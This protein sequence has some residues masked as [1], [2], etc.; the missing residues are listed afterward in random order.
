MDESA[1]ALLEQQESLGRWSFPAYLGTHY[2]SLYAL[3]V[4]WLRFRG[5]SSRLNLNRLAEIL[6]AT[7]LPDGSWAQVRDPALDSGDINATIIN[8]AALKFFRSVIGI[9]GVPEAM[10]GARE[11][12]LKSGGLAAVNQFT[13]T[14]LALFGLHT[15]EDIRDIPYLIFLDG[16][17]QNYRRFSQWVI[18]HLIP[19]AY[20][21]HNRISRRIRGTFGPEL[22][23][24]ELSA[25]DGMRILEKEARPSSWYDGL[26]VRKILHQQRSYGSWGGYT[27][28]TLLSIAALDHFNRKCP[29]HSPSIPAA[30]KRGLEFVDSLYF[31]HGEGS[32]LG[33]LMHGAVW[34]TILAAQGLV[35]AGERSTAVVRAAR[36]LYQLQVPC[37][38]FPYGKDFEAY[39][40]VDDTSRALVVLKKMAPLTPGRDAAQS[41]RKG[42]RWLLKRQNCDGGWGAFDQ[43]NVGSRIVKLFTHRLS[44][45]VELFDASS[46]DST[47]HVLRALGAFGLTLRNCRAVRR[48]VRFLQ[49]AQDPV[50]GLWE[51]RWAIN[52]LYGTA[53]AGTGLI[54][55]GESSRS[56][57]L[58]RAAR[59][60]MAL[61]NSDGGFGESTLSYIDEEYRG[62]G[63]S[64]PT[65][66][67]W[68]LEFLCHMG[69]QDTHTS[70]K[71]ANYLVETRDG[72][73]SWH[74]GSVVGTGHPGLLYM[75]YPVYPKVFPVMA[76]AAYLA[77][78]M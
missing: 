42:L 33:C 53:Q 32:Y 46:A 38:G 11:F 61:Q 6:V 31:D 39:P 66:T 57:Y 48:A 44:D 60:L 73:A 40:D 50:T 62:R 45:S 52:W 41:R 14:F 19:M 56:P 63:V 26:L 35:L 68:V 55:A 17:P 16:L 36:N 29:G 77:G 18:P 49:C 22:R 10:H 20:L 64:T 24:D 69:L 34:D 67:A 37:G 2:I 13:K 78:Q 51:G 74:D 27:V 54:Q 7:Q 75:E 4:E 70:I 72:L 47:G 21:R 12:I 3:F 58:V 9:A 76:L 5:F 25:G 71:A 59:S 65:Q 28:S 43:D 30:I 8:Y 1:Q 15:W 23:L